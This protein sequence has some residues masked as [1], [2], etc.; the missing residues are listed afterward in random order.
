LGLVSMQ[1]RLR[2]AGGTFTLISTLGQ[3]TTVEV[4]VETPQAT[5]QALADSCS[6]GSV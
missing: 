5:A 1:E 2:I 6:L 4:V 3:G